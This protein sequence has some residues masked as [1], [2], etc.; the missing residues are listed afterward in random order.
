VTSAPPPR[1][2][3]LIEELVYERVRLDAD[4]LR[5][6]DL[7]LELAAGVKRA[8]DG[9]RGTPAELARLMDRSIERACIRVAAELVEE[10]EAPSPTD[11]CPLCERPLACPPP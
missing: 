11:D 3:L 7:D 10:R 1:P 2:A 6:R 5:M 4:L 9:V 8:L